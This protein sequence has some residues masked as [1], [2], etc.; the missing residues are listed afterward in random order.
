MSR[1][2]VARAGKYASVAHFRFPD[3]AAGRGARRDA[4]KIRAERLTPL[5]RF[6]NYRG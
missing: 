5:R 3:V 1:L 2:A 4:A 6:Q